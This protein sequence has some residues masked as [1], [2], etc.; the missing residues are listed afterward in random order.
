MHISNFATWEPIVKEDMTQNGPIIYYDFVHGMS[1]WRMKLAR[2]HPKD[3]GNIRNRRTQYI[4]QSEETHFCES[5]GSPL[6]KEN[7]METTECE[8][9]NKRLKRENARKCVEQVWR[10]EI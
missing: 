2:C 7:D 5:P 3:F 8:N 9:T 4:L 6:I 10:E 1:R